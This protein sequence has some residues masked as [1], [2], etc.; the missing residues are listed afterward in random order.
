MNL[1]SQTGADA[2][3]VTCPAFA[4][5][6][7]D[8]VP[9][10]TLQGNELAFFE[11]PRYILDDLLMSESIIAFYLGE[12][13]AGKPDRTIEAIWR[14]DWQRLENVHDYIQWLFPLKESSAFNPEAPV[15]DAQTIECFRSTDLLKSKLKRS[16]EVMLDFFGLQLVELVDGQIRVDQGNGFDER[17]ENWIAARKHNHLRLTRILASTR[18]LGLEQHSL[19]LF[20]CLESI[21]NNRRNEISQTTYQFWKRA[22]LGE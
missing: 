10:I 15:L 2:S 9:C 11:V 4:R 8:I 14:W 17:G 1:S 7:I 12:R 18:T 16:F 19:A 21:Y 5:T 20:Q 3:A 22:A 13:G 6:A